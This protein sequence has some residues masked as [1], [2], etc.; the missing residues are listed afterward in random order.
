MRTSLLSRSVVFPYAGPSGQNARPLYIIID[1]SLILVPNVRDKWEGNGT[2]MPECLF[3]EA[4]AGMAVQR[5]P[6]LKAI[7]CQ[8]QLQPTEQ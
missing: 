8:P 6:K 7:E 3:Q 2:Q 1:N 4:H 5:P